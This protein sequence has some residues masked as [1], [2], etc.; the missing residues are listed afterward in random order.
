MWITLAQLLRQ[1]KM[2]TKMLARPRG[3]HVQH[4]VNTFTAYLSLKQR[5]DWVYYS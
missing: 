2:K 4:S 1:T 5:G 3:G